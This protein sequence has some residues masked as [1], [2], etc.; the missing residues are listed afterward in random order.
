MLTSPP[1]THLLGVFARSSLLIILTNVNSKGNL[2]E[3]LTNFKNFW[4]KSDGFPNFERN[5]KGN[6]Y[7]FAEI[8]KEI[9]RTPLQI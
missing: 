1:R 7:K 2:K 3:I 9:L 5:S 4:M 8:P 6:P